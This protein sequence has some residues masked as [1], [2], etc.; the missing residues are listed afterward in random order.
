MQTFSKPEVLKGQP[1]THL[2]SQLHSIYQYAEQALGI[3]IRLVEADGA[4]QIGKFCLLMACWGKSLR[5]TNKKALVKTKAEP[6]LIAYPNKH[7][8]D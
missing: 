6:K 5:F 3:V 4:Y 8:K 7:D 2:P 1:Q